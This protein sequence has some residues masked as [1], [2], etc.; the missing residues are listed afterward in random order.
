[1]EFI[2]KIKNKLADAKRDRYYRKKQ[3]P[4][5]L[6]GKDRTERAYIPLKDSQSM[7]IL[8]ENLDK[9]KVDNLKNIYQL[10]KERAYECLIVQYIPEDS[11]FDHFVPPQGINLYTIK[12]AN[13]SDLG[14]VSGAFMDRLKSKKWDIVALDLDN[15]TMPMDY[16][17]YLIQ[18]RCIISDTNRSYD[19]ADIQY[20]TAK[21]EE[22]NLLKFIVDNTTDE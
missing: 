20:D 14:E 6:E 21:N 15:L 13:I 4:W 10:Y 5:Q 22:D 12:D 16:I 2:N 3:L 1:M 18:A 8:T 19:E 17:L 7:L 9:N 11:D